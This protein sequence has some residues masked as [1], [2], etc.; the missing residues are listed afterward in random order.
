M[1]TPDDLEEELK[2]FRTHLAAL[3]KQH[4]QTLLL[5]YL[6]RI[7]QTSPLVQTGAAHTQA[8]LVRV[9]RFVSRQLIKLAHWIEPLEVTAQAE[10]SEDATMI[11]AEYRVLTP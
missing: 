11:E 4:Q 3:H 8:L 7:Q 2:A 9:R 5:R 1:N 10:V 6:T